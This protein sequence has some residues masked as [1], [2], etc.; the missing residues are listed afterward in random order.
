M[1][2]TR[3]YRVLLAEAMAQVT[4]YTVAQT[5]ARLATG[6]AV[7]I[8]IRD[9]PELAKGKVPGSVH[10]PRG[11]LEFRVDPESPFHQPFWADEGKEFILICGAGARSALAAKTLQDM[12]L[13]HVAHVGGGWDA[14]IKEGGPIESPKSPKTLETTH[15][16]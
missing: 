12:G 3:G 9:T 4:T 2:I 14:W 10:S 8:D 1:P 13:H 6:A 7:L 5:Q 16:E 15:H 11:M